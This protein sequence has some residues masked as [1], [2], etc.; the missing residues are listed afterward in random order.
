MARFEQF[1]IWELN[2][3]QWEFVA[4]FTDFELAS[5]M[6]RR[7]SYRVRLMRVVYEDGKQVEKEV[8]TE[9]GTTREQP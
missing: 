5:V 6:A 1:E 7:R 9:I 4:S 8:L 2:H 3:E